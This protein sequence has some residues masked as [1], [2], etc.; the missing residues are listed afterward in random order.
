MEDLTWPEYQENIARRLVV[1]PIGAVEAHGRHLPLSTDTVIAE[2]LAGQVSRRVPALVLPALPFGYKTDAVRVGGEFPGMTNL[3]AS[4]LTGVV[5]DVLTASYRNG[6][7]RFLIVH[8]HIA[9]LPPVFDAVDQF[10]HSAPDARV[11]AASWWDFATEETRNSIADETGVPRSEDNHAAMVETSLLMH[12]RPEAVRM[13]AAEDDDR[14]RRV[15]YLVLPVPDALR[16]RS[17]VIYA[18]K[19]A[20]PAIGERLMPEIIDNLVRAVRLELS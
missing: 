14:E 2:Y 3:R 10:V 17:G 1:L 8:G 6:A 11:M 5:Q 13:D 19:Q 15:S 4:T 18:S 9:N 7:R 16:T 20:R 12:V